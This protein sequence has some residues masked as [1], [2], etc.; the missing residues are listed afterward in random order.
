MTVRQLRQA[1]TALD[2]QS[3]TVTA[4]LLWNTGV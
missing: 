4:D 3:A 2:D 1:L